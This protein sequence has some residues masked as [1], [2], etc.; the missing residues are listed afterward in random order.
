MPTSGTRL[1]RLLLRL[2]REEARICGFHGEGLDEFAR[3]LTCPGR[4][5]GRCQA[6]M[7]P[8]DLVDGPPTNRMSLTAELIKL[9]EASLATCSHHVAC[10][11]TLQACQRCRLNCAI[12]PLAAKWRQQN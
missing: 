12:Q 5:C 8:R 7:T 2:F 4:P 1:T 10:R 9:H 3:L 6:I 11:N